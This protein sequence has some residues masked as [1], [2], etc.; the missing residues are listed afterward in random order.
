MT[1]SASEATASLRRLPSGARGASPA[2]RS[3]FTMG[4]A[5]AAAAAPPSPSALT[6]TFP[7]VAPVA[8]AAVAVAAASRLRLGGAS[9]SSS[10]LRLHHISSRIATVSTAIVSTAIV[11]RAHR[12]HCGLDFLQPPLAPSPAAVA[13]HALDRPAR[14][15]LVRMRVRVSGQGQGQG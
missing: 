14:T 13:R 12:G 11:S 7:P 1:S 4:A 9:A 2:R 5:T 8:A 15:R 3:V 10:P 6:R